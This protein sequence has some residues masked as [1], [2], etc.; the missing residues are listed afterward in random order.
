MFYGFYRE[1]HD[2]FLNR[3]RRFRPRYGISPRPGKMAVHQRVAPVLSEDRNFMG[4]PSEKQMMNVSIA[5]PSRS[6]SRVPKIQSRD[7]EGPIERYP[8]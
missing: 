2:N 6:S 5:H 1:D 7:G 4:G 3:F 8:S